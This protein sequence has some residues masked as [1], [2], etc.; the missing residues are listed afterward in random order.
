MEQG[1]IQVYTGDGKGKTTAAIGLA[2]RAWGRGLKVKVYQF[3]KTAGGSGE[4]WALMSFDPPI[5]LF[6]FGDGKFIY[7]DKPTPKD[8]EQALNGW[9][10]IDQAI[11]SDENDVIVIDEL[12]HVMNKRLLDPNMVLATLVKKPARL[13]LVLT[14]RDMPISI[15]ELADLVT[16][17]KMVKHP[18]QYGL[19]AR[20]G[21][22]F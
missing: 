17:M 18:Y 15:L 1:I 8:I 2:V 5:P 19:A 10:Q 14:G 20:E 7:T 12:S 21:I 11:A 22:E 4:H 3:L 16:E 9:K 6:T 13:E